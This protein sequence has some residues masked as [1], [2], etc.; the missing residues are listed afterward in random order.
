MFEKIK[1]SFFLFKLALKIYTMGPIKRKLYLT[2][3]RFNTDLNTDLTM[4]QKEAFHRFLDRIES[5]L[6]DK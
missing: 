1:T 4:E 3:L 5:N 6:E 2:Q